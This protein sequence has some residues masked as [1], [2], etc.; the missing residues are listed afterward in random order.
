M[1]SSIINFFYGW[2]I[3]GTKDFW[4]WFINFIK[5]LDRDAGLVG[6]VQNWLSPL[7]GDYS[8]IG[9]VAGP[10]F[11]TFRIFFGLALYTAIFIISLAV[12][13]IWI[14]LPVMAI[15][16]ILLNFLSF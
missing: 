3:D 5:Y 2:Y 1:F 10:I 12:F 9:I 4:R 16:I 8:Y 7:Y 11:R 14:I 13:L 15:R 6:N